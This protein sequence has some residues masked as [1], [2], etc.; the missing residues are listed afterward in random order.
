LKAAG[1]TLPRFSIQ[2]KRK[3]NIFWQS[4]R[5]A[6]IIG[7][8]RKQCGHFF[9]ERA[10]FQLGRITEPGP[11]FAA[12]RTS[13]NVFVAIGNGLAVTHNQWVAT[14]RGSWS[15]IAGIRASVVNRVHIARLSMGDCSASQPKTQCTHGSHKQLFR[16]HRIT[17]YHLIIL[18]WFF[19]YKLIR[20]EQSGSAQF[21]LSTKSLLKLT[22]SF[23]NGI[24]E[25]F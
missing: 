17:L 1:I 6:G 5:L 10:I 22:A 13:Y 25:H 12:L 3:Q 24:I 2:F 4:C 19:R 16:V 9:L 21:P 15:E 20:Q 7:F 23:Q 11:I 14:L 8:S 18:E